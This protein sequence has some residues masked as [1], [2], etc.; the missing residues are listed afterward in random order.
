[1]VGIEAV[2]FYAALCYFRWA[3]ILSLVQGGMWLA[4]RNWALNNTTPDTT[5]AGNYDESLLDVVVW[6]CLSELL[7]LEVLPEPGAVSAVNRSP[8]LVLANVFE[9]DHAHNQISFKAATPITSSNPSNLSILNYTKLFQPAAYHVS[10]PKSH[11]HL[12]HLQ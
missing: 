3:G 11:V 1:M 4:G 10:S 8:P 7:V 9:T 6:A 5:S 2:L 12:P